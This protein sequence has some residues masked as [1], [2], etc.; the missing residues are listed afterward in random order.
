MPWASRTCTA[1]VSVFA[2]TAR[3]IATLIASILAQACTRAVLIRDK[4]TPTRSPRDP[5][6][7]RACRNSVASA[8][9]FQVPIR[10]HL[11]TFLRR[12]QVHVGTPRRPS[13]P[14]CASRRSTW[15]CPSQPRRQYRHQQCNTA[16]C[17][18]RHQRATP[19]PPASASPPRPRF[20]FA[21]SVSGSGSA[22]NCLVY[23]SILAQLRPSSRLRHGACAL[24]LNKLAGMLMLHTPPLSTAR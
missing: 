9:H 22:R 14:R 1:M 12:A 18:A 11:H 3:L 7:T 2:L 6:T 5:T 17:R 21:I 23:L 19:H 13:P 15:L 4:Q 16:T 10:N 8:A 20:P 24:R